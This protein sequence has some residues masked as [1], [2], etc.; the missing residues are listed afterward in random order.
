MK[1]DGEGEV[2]APSILNLSSKFKQVINFTFCSLDPEGRTRGYG[3]VGVEAMAK[4][5][6]P[7]PAT[8]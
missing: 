7:A 2:S 8:K 5:K 1:T 4:R 3:W 6:I